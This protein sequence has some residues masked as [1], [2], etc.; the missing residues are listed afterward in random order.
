MA[1][2]RTPEEL[3]RIRQRKEFVQSKP[4]LDPAKA[5]QQFFVQTRAKELEKSGVEVTKERRAALRQKFASGNVQRAGFYTPTDI[6]KFTGNNNNTNNTNNTTSTVRQTGGYVSSSMRKPIPGFNPGTVQKTSSKS[7]DVGFKAL[8]KTVLFGAKDIVNST[9]ESMQATFVNPAVN[10]VQQM[11]GKKSN[12]RQAGLVES[13]INTADV[14]ATIYT[15]GGSKALTSAASAAAKG[16]S[17]GLLNKNAVRTATV[18]DTFA[19]N[20]AASL[21]ASQNARLY[22]GVTKLPETITSPTSK[23]PAKSFG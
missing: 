19:Q 21:A 11:R 8:G 23:P 22:S 6:A 7:N 12:L 4:E 9:L 14:V 2:K 17:K 20:R 15:A 16:I 1:K 18:L 10:S 13:A 3:E 5:R